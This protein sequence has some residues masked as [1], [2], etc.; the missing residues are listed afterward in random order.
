MAT[1]IDRDR[2]ASWVRLDSAGPSH[3]PG[4]GY[5]EQHFSVKEIA[6]MWKLSP[7]AIRRMFGNEPGVL[8]FGRQKHGHTRDYVTLRIPASVVERVHRRC[9]R[10]GPPSGGTI[11]GGFS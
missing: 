3:K 10:P 6:E 1:V 11:K 7:A 4:S 9:A 5:S 8:R 2:Q